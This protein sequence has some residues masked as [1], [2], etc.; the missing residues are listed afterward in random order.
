MWDGCRRN[1]CASPPRAYRH[2]QGG[3]GGRRSQGG[4]GSRGGCRSG[5]LRPRCRG[6]RGSCGRRAAHPRFAPAAVVG[7]CRSGRARRPPCDRNTPVPCRILPIGWGGRRGVHKPLRAFARGRI[8]GGQ[9]RAVSRCVSPLSPGFESTH[10][11]PRLT[12]CGVFVVRGN[13]HGG[14]SGCGQGCGCARSSGALRKV[15]GRG[16]QIG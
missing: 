9:P 7:G 10:A 15:Q 11:G 1:A 5:R 16:S 6:R 2:V 3:G 8:S 4:H 14:G 13:R 12:R